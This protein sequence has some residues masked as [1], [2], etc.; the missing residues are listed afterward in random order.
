MKN[1]LKIFVVVAGM[2]SALYSCEPKQAENTV[3]SPDSVS[4]ETTAAPDS[5]AA[6]QDST[7][8]AKEDSTK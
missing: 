8:T 2:A 4:S 7:T 5:L 3:T 6:E 1:L